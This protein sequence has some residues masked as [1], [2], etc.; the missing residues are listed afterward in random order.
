[1]KTGK[2]DWVRLKTR[3]AYSERAR[4]FQEITLS[5][6]Q[7]VPNSQLVLA[8]VERMKKDIVEK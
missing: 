2:Y 6:N 3:R 7:A 1:M 8:L 4:F 5:S